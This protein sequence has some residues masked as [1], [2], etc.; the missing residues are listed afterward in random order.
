[1]RGRKAMPNPNHRS[2]LAASCLPFSR[3]CIIVHCRPFF[4]IHYLISFRLIF[5]IRGCLFQTQSRRFHESMHDARFFRFFS[6]DRISLS[7]RLIALFLLSLR[8]PAT[9]ILSFP[10]ARQDFR[11]RG[12]REAVAGTRA[13]LDPHGIRERRNVSIYL[14]SGCCR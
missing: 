8:K 6:K 9:I 3:V 10:F 4:S 13:R 7:M 12:C 11:R 2:R 14:E 5:F 1:M